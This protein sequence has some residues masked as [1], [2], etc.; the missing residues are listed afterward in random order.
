[1]VAALVAVVVAAGC[2]SSKAA[3]GT[4]KKTPA[5][6]VAASSCLKVTDELGDTV[7]DLPVVPCN[8]S[9]THEVFAKVPDTATDVYPGQAALET[10]AQQECYAAF[11]PFVGV[12]PFDSQLYI[13]WILPSLDGWNLHKDRDVL[14]VLGMQN[15]APMTTSAKGTKV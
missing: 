8:V 10:F 3:P 5:L 13:S 12:S 9:H 4:P 6:D 15:G 7:T 2:S 11:T 1:V 14:C